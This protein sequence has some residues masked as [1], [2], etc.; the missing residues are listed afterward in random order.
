MNPLFDKEEFIS[1]WKESENCSPSSPADA[2]S[3]L[4]DY[5]AII[6]NTTPLPVFVLF[7]QDPY[8]NLR[9]ACGRSFLYRGNVDRPVSMDML[10]K[11]AFS[12]SAY[13]FCTFIDDYPVRKEDNV[14]KNERLLA[15]N[16]HL[17]TKLTEDKKEPS[18]QH[19]H[20]YNFTQRLFTKMFSQ[21]CLSENVTTIHVLLAGSF[22]QNM[23]KDLSQQL[24]FCI[25]PLIISKKICIYKCQHPSHLAR[26]G[27]SKIGDMPQFLLDNNV[28]LS[29][30]LK[31][32]SDFLK[33]RGIAC[34]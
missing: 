20:W 18:G 15:L 6:E 34:L 16:V 33:T 11:V 25:D 14:G 26:T 2:L 3:F 10:Y 27:G 32:Y 31:K 17:T 19:K 4:N 30:W 24:A 23:W 8:P 12:V 28:T 29:I 7:G 1:L 13:H 22:P 9:H 21:L 5:T